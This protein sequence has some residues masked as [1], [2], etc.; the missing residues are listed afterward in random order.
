VTTSFLDDG[1][2]PANRVEAGLSANATDTSGT[3]VRS[4]DVDDGV[5]VIMYGHNASAIISG[6]TLTL[7]PYQ[8]PDRTVLWRCGLSAA[9]TNVVELGTGSG[10]VAAYIAPTV[11]PQYLPSNCRAQ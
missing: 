4:I 9:P 8:T 7:T 3:Y 1:R 10:N 11:Q 6:L 2:A 5:L